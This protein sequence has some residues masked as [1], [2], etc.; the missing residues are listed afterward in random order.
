MK[1]ITESSSQFAIANMP[2][3]F[4]IKTV[5]VGVP[6]YL[7]TTLNHKWNYL[8]NYTP[9]GKV[10]FIDTFIAAGSLFLFG[11][12][13]NYA[14]TLSMNGKVA[15]YNASITMDLFHKKMIS[16][17]DCKK[18]DE[19][20]IQ[21]LKTVSYKNILN[22]IFGYDPIMGIATAKTL[23]E[24]GAMFMILPY[25]YLEPIAQVGLKK[26]IEILLELQRYPDAERLVIV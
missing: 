2:N 26:A 10:G 19:N 1:K 4:G 6:G 14:N 9:D 16:Y 5:V 7:A 23:M 22:P 3:M 24:N 18:F 11:M 12:P 20:L 17:D 13:A 25:N 15:K 8:P 21:L